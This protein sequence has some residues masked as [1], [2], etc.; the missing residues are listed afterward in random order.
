[1]KRKLAPESVSNRTFAVGRL[2]R[3]F[4]MVVAR[5]SVSYSKRQRFS[6]L[7]LHRHLQPLLLAPHK[8]YDSLLQRSE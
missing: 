2:V 4:N 3:P 1:M 7:T 8:R 6:T 5:S